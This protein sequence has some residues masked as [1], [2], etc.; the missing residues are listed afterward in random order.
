MY[1]WRADVSNENDRRRTLDVNALAQEQ[2]DRLP[3]I[4]A[5]I[6]ALLRTVDP[7]ELLSHLT[8]LYQTHA[9]D[10]ANDRNERARWQ[11]KIEWLAWLALSRKIASPE[12]PAVIDGGFLSALERL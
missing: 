10:A 4:V 5:E 7:I 2:R 9:T 3:G 12:R 6:E 1:S 8:V 11:A